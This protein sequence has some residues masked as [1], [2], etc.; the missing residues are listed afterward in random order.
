MTYFW[1]HDVFFVVVSVWRT[2]S[3]HDEHFWRH[4]IFWRH[5]V[6]FNVM[7]IILTPRRTFDV[8]QSFW[9][10]D[11]FLTSRGNFLTPWWF[12]WRHEELCDVMTYCS[13]ASPIVHVLFYVMTNILTSWRTFWRHDALFDIMMHFVMSWRNIWHHDVFL[14]SWRTVWRHDTLIDVMTHFVTL[15]EL[16]D[17]MTYF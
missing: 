11:V 9:R 12:V 2:V 7:T 4:D 8:I 6:L 13:C 14:K 1:R 10:H 16:F 17:V 3:R 5:D 15:H